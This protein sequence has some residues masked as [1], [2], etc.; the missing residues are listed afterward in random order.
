MVTNSVAFEAGQVGLV[1]TGIATDELM[2]PVEEMLEEPVGVV[3]E[4]EELEELDELDELEGVML[5]VLKAVDELDGPDA[6]EELEELEGVTLNILEAVEELDDPELE[7]LDVVAELEELVLK[8]VEETDDPD[9]ICDVADEVVET[10]LAEG[11]SL[12]SLAPLSPELF[13]VLP[14]AFFI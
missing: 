12:N 7:L 13:T 14:I 8:A 2:D 11:P 1:E 4:P 6:L 10:V 9:E 5:D 3:E